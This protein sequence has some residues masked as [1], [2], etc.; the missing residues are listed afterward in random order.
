MDV[1]RRQFLNV[2][3][4]TTAA[5]VVVS[6]EMMGQQPSADSRRIRAIAFDGFV[7]F[8]P[9]FV[10]KR[11]EEVIPGKGMAFTNLWR[12]RQFDYS[13]LRTAGQQYEDFWR[14][15]E[16][17]LNYAA[18][19][20]KLSLSPGQRERL[21]SAYLQL[22]VWPDVPEALAELRRRGT[23]VAF[24]SNLTAAMLDACLTAAKLNGYFEPHLTTDRV[25]VYKP[26]PR[27]Y[28]MGVDAFDLKRDEIAF[29]ASAAWDAAGAKWFGYPTVWVNRP[30]GVMEELGARPD[31]ITADLSGLLDFV[32]RRR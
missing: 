28:Q 6:A 26:S 10:A 7:I 13:W 21:M 22:P 27:S 17:A 9:R 3:A 8:D 24:L 30:N 20:M 1:N 16:S 23:R 11:V 25:R 29:V 12:T 19:S 2:A 5:A 4:G 14:V 32:A 18:L 15:T 31:L